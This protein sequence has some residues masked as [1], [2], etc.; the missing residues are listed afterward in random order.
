MLAQLDL[1]CKALVAEVAG[2]GVDGLVHGLDVS[3]EVV[4]VVEGAVAAGEAA[5]ELLLARVRQQV[6]AQVV[7]APKGLVAARVRAGERGL[8]IDIRWCIKSEY[9]AKDA[10]RG[11]FWPT[12]R[13]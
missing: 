12:S 9:E 1:L 2:V 4:R 13:E 8:C 3:L 5:G 7:A 10:R 11:N 6:P